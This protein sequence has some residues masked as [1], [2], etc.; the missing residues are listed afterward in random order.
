M[1]K[2]RIAFFDS[3]PYDREFFTA[4]NARHGFGLTFFEAKLRP[5]TAGLADGF[6]AICLHCGG[7]KNCPGKRPGEHCT[8]NLISK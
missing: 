4:A 2:F 8:S 3:K 6:D 5:Q 1:E 7:T